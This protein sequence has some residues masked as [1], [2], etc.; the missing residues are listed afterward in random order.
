L[1]VFDL[2][3][4]HFSGTARTGLPT[5][6]RS[7]L[8]DL[9]TN[10][11]RTDDG[12]FPIDR[13]AR[14]Y[15]DYLDRR[16]PRYGHDGCPSEHGAF[17][18]TKG[19]NFGGNGHFSIDAAISA[20]ENEAGSVDV[21]DPLVG[22]QVDMWG[23]HNEYL[24]TTVNRAR[25]F[26]VDP[27]AN[28]TTALMV[29]RFCFGRA[30]RSHDVGY[31]ATGTVQ[32][33]HAP[34]WQNPHHT[35]DIGEHWL[36]AELAR[37]VVYQ[38]VIE[39]VRWLDDS[40]PAVRLLK[41]TAAD[42]I[43]VQFALSGMSVPE[44]PD[45]PCKWELRGTI[46]PWHADELRT[47]PAGRLLVPVE[48]GAGMHDLSVGLSAEH[49]TFNLVTALSVRGGAPVDLG[50]LSLRTMDTDDLVA[51]LP[52]KAYLSAECTLTSGVVVV[53]AAAPP[54]I[55]DDQALC[56]VRTEPA[57]ERRLLLS[58]V[59]TNVQSDDACLILEHTNGDP[60]HDVEVTVRSFVRGRPR[61]VDVP[62]RQRDRL[63]RIGSVSTDERGWGRCTVR[64]ERAGVTRVQLCDAGTIAV[65]VL[66]DDWYLDRVPD[67]EVTFDL[68]YE[69]VFAYYELMYSFMG[70]EV[71][72]LADRCKVETYATL[73][74]QMCDP[75]NRA[76]TYYMPS[77]RDMSEAR[78]RLL[79]RFLRNH[80]GTAPRIV[81]ADTAAGQQQPIT[82]RGELTVALRQAVTLELAVMLQYLYA[83]YS[84]PTHGAG[85]TLVRRGL[86]TPEQLDLACGDGGR[87]R[88]T[89]I[90]G[91]LLGIAREEM[92]HFLVVNNILMAIG[93]P[94][95]S[96]PVD[97]G[98]I[99]SE[100][101]VPV[102]FALEP[103]NVG[104]TQ[105]FVALERPADPE[106][107]GGSYR[108]LSEL[109]GTLREG[110]L[111]V[112][113]LFLVRPGR[114]GGEHHLFLRESVDTVHPDY[115]LEV[116]DLSSALFAIDFVTE[117]GEGAVL[118]AVAGMR[119]ESHHD[120]FRRV[121]KLL[122]TEELRTEGPAWEPAYPVL[123]N[124]TVRSGNGALELVTEPDTARIMLLFNRSY[125]MMQQLMAQH[126]GERP[127]ASLR[128][129]DLMNSAIDVMAGMMRPLAELLVTLPAGRTGRT[130]GPSFELDETPSHLPRPDVARRAIALRFTHLAAAC[131][132]ED[133][134]PSR[135]AEL[136]TQLAERFGR[137]A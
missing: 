1:S 63:L 19:W 37:S 32:G 94:F 80:Q 50:D 71:F 131:R 67:H 100:L 112:P 99:N 35:L 110:L 20:V 79:F 116:D 14:E 136:S 16:P 105:R 134:V 41:S 9:T 82:T 30:G 133:R 7:G 58:E 121:A 84:V 28:D 124:P 27:T 81:A 8:V 11:V 12:P 25:V 31:A 122:M 36:T 125:H 74:W 102:D 38:F 64:G 119:E 77:T 70:D 49:V 10:T 21:D 90:R 47:Y 106:C 54:G 40:S 117:Q 130:A 66:P 42:G 76:K 108:S 101:P 87:T 129:S 57:G 126:F 55:A 52:S 73:V 34:R 72:S 135:V 24:A 96:P 103:L 4:L 59:E 132:R 114:G 91:T 92:M 48:P 39:E 85:L 3:R 113:D 89:G 137:Q 22:R 115:Q 2:P 118:P 26:D 83:A 29:G 6:P 17:S 104:S 53:P 23:H 60:R 120:I 62:M 107:A 123:R 98:T 15:H 13:P 93:E 69:K 33:V 65:R 68:L 45:V 18:A 86:W 95:F 75:R 128:R 43:V 44:L 127:D 46:A 109:Y 78:A 111:R 56:L 61:A 88:H 51:M 5:G 97:F